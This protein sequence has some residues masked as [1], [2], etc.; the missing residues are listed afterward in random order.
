MKIQLIDSVLSSSIWQLLYEIDSVF[1]QL[2]PLSK[3]LEAVSEILIEVLNV[4]SVWFLTIDPLTSTACGIVRTPLSIAPDARVYIADE[5]PPIENGWP[6]TLLKQVMIRKD[7]LF[8]QPNIIKD[9]KI[10]A[11][12]ADALFGTFN[13]TPLAIMPLVVDDIVLGALIIGN[14][15]RS[16]VPLSEDV[17]NLLVYL[18]KPLAKNLHIIYLKERSKRHTITLT[19]LNHIAQTITSSLD[20]DDVIQRTMA[21]INA[22]LDVE[23]G[24]L[25]LLNEEN[26][27][28]YFKVTLRGEN[29]QVTSYRLK[30]GEGIAGWVMEHNKPAV[31]DDVTTDKRFSSKIDKAIGFRTKSVLCVPLVIQG[32]PIGVM[33]VLNKRS[34][35]FDDDD[36]TLLISMVASLSIALKNATLYVDAQRRAQTHEIISQITAAINAGHG[37]S[38]TARIIFDQSKRLFDFN[39]ISIS[40][41]DDSKEKVRQWVFGEYGSI[42]QMKQIALPNSAL[43]QIIKMG[44]GYVEADISKPKSRNKIYPDDEILL[45]DNIKA[46]ATV[47]LTTRSKPY[48]HLSL[49]SRKVGAY[50]LREL[51]LLEQLAPQIAV[52]IEKALLIDAMERRTTELQLLNRFGEMLVSTTNV[53]LIFDTA[54]N[55]IPRLVPGDVQGLVIAS[56]EGTYVGVA[57]PFDFCKTDET[58]RN[59]IQ[60]F[61][62]V[63]EDN[64]PVDHIISKSIAGNMP[65]PNDWTPTSVLSL[66]ILTRRGTQG[67]IYVASGKEETF[68]DNLLHIFSLIVSQISAAVENAHL[69]QQVEQERARLAAIL[70]SS[71]D[72]VLVVNRN[73]RIVLDNPA[74]WAVIGTKE[75]KVG[76]LLVDST[77]LVALI[78]LFESAMQGG[79]PTGEIALEDGRTFFANLSPVSVGE[80]G[81]IGWVATMQDVSHF[82]ELNQLKNDFVNTVS[83]DLRSPLSTILM[84]TNLIGD[85]GEL[86][87]E[88]WSLLNVIDSR[89]K[90][91]SHLIDNLL[92]VGKIEA[93]I[94]MEMEACDLTAMIEE[95]TTALLP[96]AIVKN[97]KVVNIVD[98]ELPS[99][100]GNTIRLRQVIH[101]LM[102]NAIKYTLNEGTVTVKAYLHDDNEIRLQVVDT[103]IGIPASDRPHVFEKFYRVR[104]SHALTIKG[105]GLGLAIVKSIVEKHQGRVWLESV[106]GEGSTFTLALP[107]YQEAPIFPEVLNFREDE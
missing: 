107:V 53:S 71:T 82:K 76:R 89:V 59:M 38:E 72:A 9:S 25:I 37:L 24:S 47:P 39:H 14:R 91:M 3:Q 99:V 55:M 6:A 4:D 50:G 46:K 88:Q 84:A 57:V 15:N 66:P 54:L 100:M 17:R 22:I 97:I 75:S 69:F 106:V 43:A 34:G 101:N 5:S 11:D 19:T 23:A 79:K 103:G 26:D 83:H 98:Q 12:L 104:G 16:P 36:K 87:N 8:L 63:S 33:E 7:P 56:D 93:G 44:Q 61:L 48:G 102:S 21:G 77:H 85:A 90:S 78:N 29:R 13:V 41:L 52:A 67:I 73:G 92:D 31:V 42:E 86:N 28:L 27:E 70:A 20:I 64:L 30:R 45:L 18:G 80:T 105:T 51:E 35:R 94:D 65:V 60:T 32:K 1:E 96:Q 2:L 74:A 49:G 81:V 68:N 40:L 58:I 10:D 62:E 95:V